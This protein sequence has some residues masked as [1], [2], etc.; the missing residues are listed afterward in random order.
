MSQDIHYTAPYC[1]SD[2]TARIPSMHCD[3]AGDSQ[4]PIEAIQENTF[5]FSVFVL[6]GVGECP[7]YNLITVHNGE[8]DQ[9]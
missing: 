9:T 2:G 6:S 4:K 7:M 8:I 3:G 5:I 1:V